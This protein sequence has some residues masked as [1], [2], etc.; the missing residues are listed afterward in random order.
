MNFKGTFHIGIR[1]AGTFHMSSAL[2]LVKSDWSQGF[3]MP[4]IEGLIP[5]EGNIKASVDCFSSVRIIRFG[6]S[7]S[8]ETLF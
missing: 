7:S 5:L 8:S 6:L 1:V 2:Q 3:Y 4:R